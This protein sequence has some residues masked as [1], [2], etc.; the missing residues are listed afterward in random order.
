MPPVRGGLPVPTAA[1]YRTSAGLGR[2]RATAD[3]RAPAAD[4]RAEG[5]R[6]GAPSWV[7]RGLRVSE[8]G[9]ERRCST[10]AGALRRALMGWHGPYYYR[11]RRIG[12][13]VVREYVGV[14]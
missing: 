2:G 10:N 13:R 6:A 5:R 3:G 1:D 14:G 11:S 12:G 4:R 7:L 8:A 9:H